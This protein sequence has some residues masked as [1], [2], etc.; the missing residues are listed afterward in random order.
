MKK[1]IHAARIAAFSIALSSCAL[2]PLMSHDTA[3]S[4]G[5]GV[6]AVD[7][8]GTAINGMVKTGIGVTDNLDLGAQLEVFS[9]GLRAKYSLLN[10]REQG[11]SFALAGGTGW[12]HGGTHRYADIIGSYKINDFEFYSTARFVHAS[13]TEKDFKDAN[14]GQSVFVIAQRDYDYKQYIFGIRYW[15]TDK[16]LFD[17]EGTK[18]SFDDKEIKFESPMQ[19]G[20]GLGFRF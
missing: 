11:L 15:I 3:R 17:I 1:L 19:Y 14:T 8:A 6:A 4:L 2:G 5:E 16:I 7:L 12:S 18:I 20:A 9:F 13:N 10:N